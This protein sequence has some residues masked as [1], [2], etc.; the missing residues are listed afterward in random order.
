MKINNL[1]K[2]TLIFILNCILITQS[3]KA[4]MSH[5]KFMQLVPESAVT[6]KAIDSGLWSDASNW[7][8]ARVPATGANVQ[9][10][11]GLELEYDS[12]LSPRIKTIRVDGKLSFADDRNTKLIV[13]YIAVVGEG[14]LQIGTASN[15]IPENIKTNIVFAGVDANNTAIDLSWDPEQFSRGLVAGMNA[16]IDI[17]GA[18]KTSYTAINGNHL[19]GSKTI[20]LKN[21]PND[22]KVGD[23]IV[24]TGTEWGRKKQG[25]NFDDNSLNRDEFL[26]IDSISGNNISFHHKNNPNK[27]SLNYDHKLV[28]GFDF[29]IYLANLSRNIVFETEARE[30]APIKEWAHSMFMSN[31]T[32]IEYA[33]FIAM[34]RTNKNKILNDAKLNGNGVLVPG[35]G[36]NQRGRYAIHFHR[37]FDHDYDLNKPVHVKGVSA[38]MTMGWG[39]TTHHSASIVEDSVVFDA[40]GAGFVNEDGTEQAIYRRNLAIKIRGSNQD[41]VTDLLQPKDARGKALDF[42]ARGNGFWIHSPYSSKEFTDNIAVSTDDAGTLVWGHNDPGIAQFKVPMDKVP[43]YIQNLFPNKSEIFAWKVPL[44]NFS[45]NLA[46]NVR[47]ALDLRGVT[48]DDVGFDNFNIHHLEQSFVK[49]QRAWALRENGI[50][51]EYAAHITIETPLLIGN[52][53]NPITFNHKAS[54]HL[55]I[56][57]KG[58]YSDKNARQWSQHFRWSCFQK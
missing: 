26:V 57:G 41:G 49:N 24:L 58:I 6:H 50:N 45:D 40:V 2:L 42:A 21:M 11:S 19:A 47:N 10:P 20:A 36:T 23:V 16:D 17:H 5:M 53:E 15:P 52:P 34:G 27:D 18:F 4:D 7:E 28:D 29:E 25:D 38:C 43:Q 1:I 51:I 56:K 46:Y 3:V 39:I 22:W 32:D 33:Q 30:A 44:R 12:S 37:I 8:N 9:I 35:T 14:I 55:N 31:T 54:N 48:R 13:D